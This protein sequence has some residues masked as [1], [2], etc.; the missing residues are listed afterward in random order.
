MGCENMVEAR[1]SNG[2]ER[3]PHRP[4]LS[5]IPFWTH[6]NCKTWVGCHHKTQNP[7]RPL[8]ILATPEMFE[9]RK[10]IHALIDPI[11]QSGDYPRGKIYAYMSKKLGVEYHTG[12]L[13]TME[14]AREAW[15]IAAELNNQ[16]KFDL[17][18]K[19]K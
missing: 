12:E 8:G 10:A 15:K 11:W 4:D 5:N 18:I 17:E 14:E 19:F 9:A 13:K 6:D 2:S 3:Y 7:T 1:L 16:Y